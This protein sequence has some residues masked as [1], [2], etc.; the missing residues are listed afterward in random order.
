MNHCL[1]LAAA[2]VAYPSVNPDVLE[3]SVRN[4]V[5]HALSRAPT[6]EVAVSGASI[7]FSALWATNG[8][9][10]TDRAVRIVSSQR[11][12]GRWFFH[13]GDVTPAALRQLRRAAGIQQ[14]PLKLSIFSNHI[15][16]IARQ[17]KIPFALA[18]AKVR[19]LGID[20]IA[21][22]HPMSAENLAEVRRQGFAVSCVI[23]WTRFEN[24][25]NE[26]LCEALISCA[27][28]NDC[29]QVMLVPGF[30]PSRAEDLKLRSSII[31][32]TARF[33]QAA[34]AA[35][36]ETLVE[37][38][39]DEKSPTCGFARTKN[40]L[41]AVPALGFVY[42]TG[43][44]NG[45]GEIAE[46]GVKLLRRVRHFHLK[47][48]PEGDPRGSCA[49][50]AGEIPVAEIISSA[51]DAGY[52]GWFTIEHFNFRPFPPLGILAVDDCGRNELCT[53]LM[54]QAKN[55][56]ENNYHLRRA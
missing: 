18:A 1:V 45:P 31:Q 39:D 27:V 29:A 56:Q 38:F 26:A 28:A 3:P 37:D 4:E 9:S 52:G 43:N 6:N 33:A 50:G 35:G 11:C 44:F 5:D 55:R 17:E 54:N 12:D 19:A 14:P 48:R 25:Y 2:I 30:Y 42:D 10:A 53:Y 20:G 41:D 51:L 7:A 13:G 49:V 32:S 24:G 40:F 36:L 8:L 46:S 22:F 23:G 34:A 15:E 21:V 47:D 16:D